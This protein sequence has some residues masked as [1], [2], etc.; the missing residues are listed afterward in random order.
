MEIL[1]RKEA[2]LELSQRLKLNFDQYFNSAYQ[3]N[4]WFTPRFVR[5]AIYELSEMLNSDDLDQFCETYKLS[6]ND[7]NIGVILAGNI[8][9]VGFHDLFCVLISGANL[10]LQLSSKDSVLMRAII[11]ELIS[12]E[13]AFN[14]KIKL[15]DRLDFSKIDMLIFTGSNT[16]AAQ[17]D[18]I[19][20]GLKKIIRRNM[21]SVA[22]V[23]NSTSNEELQLLADDLFLYY[24]LGCRNV[25]KLYLPSGFD[26]SRIVKAFDSFKFLSENVAYHNNY[27][28]QKAIFTINKEEFVD[29]GFY[30]L[31]SSV[32]LSSPMSCINYEFY[33]DKAVLEKELKV[34]PNIQALV[35]KEQIPF[36]NSQKPSL[37]DFADGVDT[38]K[39]IIGID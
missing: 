29:G 26:L 24:G 23:D 11:N 36:G 21:S 28:K 9:A 22:I 10:H 20:S 33:Q 39:E 30:L 12:I 17:V 7:K 19:S 3:Q 16:V 15:Y 37:F 5:R 14:Q 2:F 35:S 8:P 32:A 1:R 34:N 27:L 38:V 18:Y 6:E 13:P 31:R 25:S 4:C